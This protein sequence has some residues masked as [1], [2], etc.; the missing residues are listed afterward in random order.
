MNKQNWNSVYLDNTISDKLI[1]ELIDNSYE[2]IVKSLK[3]SLQEYLR[4]L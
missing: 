4:K 1:C 3:K 2:L